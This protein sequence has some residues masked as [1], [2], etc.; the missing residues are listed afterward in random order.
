MVRIFGHYIPKNLFLLGV[1]EAAILLAAMYAGASF[2]AM[3]GPEPAMANNVLAASLLFVL[4]MV[5]VMTVLGLYQR[6]LQEG[7]WGY[8]PR[9]GASFVLGL[10]LMSLAFQVA[11]FLSVATGAFASAF[12][13]AVVGVTSARLLYLRWGGVH[14]AMRRVLVLGAGKP[15]SKLEALTAQASGRRTFRIVGYVPIDGAPDALPSRVL[16]DVASLEAAV[17]KHGVDEI[18]VAVRD[19]RAGLPLTELLAC[20]LKGVRIVDLPTFFE[21]ESGRLEIDALSPGWLIFSDG[22]EHSPYK[23]ALKRTF[24]LAASSAVLLLAWPVMLATAILI[25]LEDQGPVFYRQE[26]VGEDGRTFKLIKFRSMRVDAEGSGVPQ[27]A[28]QDDDRV[29]R[30]GRIIR[31]MRL[32]EFP[33]VFNVFKG[34]MSFVGPRPERPYFVEQLKRSVPYYGCRHAVKPGITGWAQVRYPY[35]ASVE[36]A[37]QK[38]QYDLYYIKNNS[39]FL[40]VIILFQTLRVLISTDGAR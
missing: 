30:V 40:D 26:R 18:V 13:L 2:Y 16:A 11:P 32:D 36:D 38:L 6:D 9:L 23:R 4:V 1:I 12:G 29:T 35:G 21:R 5:T 20:K 39:L 28:K 3:E 25:Y 37:M 31:K 24:D 33:Q 8:F 15:A 19:R 17:R 22:F 7:E 14:D 34:E 10:L 27:W